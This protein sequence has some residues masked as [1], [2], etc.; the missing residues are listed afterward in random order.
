M[1]KYDAVFRKLKAENEAL[2]RKNAS[3]NAELKESRH[4]SILKQLSDYKLQ[5]DYEKALEVLERIPPEILSVYNSSD[6]LDR[7]QHSLPGR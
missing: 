2:T 1:K 7:Q 5:S 6:K 4:E 3:M